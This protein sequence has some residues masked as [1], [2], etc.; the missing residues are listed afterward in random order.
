MYINV[1]VFLGLLLLLFVLAVLWFAGRDYKRGYSRP[2]QWQWNQ[3]NNVRKGIAGEKA[4]SKILSWLPQREYRVFNN[5]LLNN[6]LGGT[7]QIDH[8]VVSRFGV[9][10]IET[11]NFGG[12]VYGSENAQYWNEYFRGKGFEFY[13]P[14]LQNNTHIAVLKENLVSFENVPFFSVVAFPPDAI[15]R[16]SVDNGTKVLCWDDLLELFRE[17]KVERMSYKKAQAFGFELDRIQIKE[18]EIHQKHAEEV[19]AHKQRKTM[20]IQNGICPRCGGKL[21]RRKGKY[22]DFFGCSNYPNCKFIQ[23]ID[24]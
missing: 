11:K 9:F 3:Y 5:V 17:I 21:V 20:A 15:L 14:V 13:N 7:S 2:K 1:F 6:P 23:G 8:I 18:I 19:R 12:K 22:G 10:V 4:V 16:V 24:D